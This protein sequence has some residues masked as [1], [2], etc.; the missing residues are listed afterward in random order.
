M[1]FRF[2]NSINHLSTA[3][4]P[5][6]ITPRLV[7][8]A[9]ALWCVLAASAAPASGRP[10]IVTAPDGQEVEVTPV[11]DEHSR[12]FI[13]TQSGLPEDWLPA[14]SQSIGVRPLSKN[15]LGRLSN[16]TIEFNRNLSG[17]SVD[18]TAVNHAASIDYTANASQE[19]T[20]KFLVILVDF[21][22]RPFVT[23]DAHTAFEDIMNS[24]QMPVRGSY[25]SARKY[26][27]EQ[28][29]GQFSPDFDVVGPVT[30][31]RN[32]SY[33]A[34]V[35]VDDSPTGKVVKEACE[36]L[37]DQL[38]FSDYDL[39]G[40]GIC[41][42]IYLFY[43]GKGQADGGGSNTIWPHS[44][45]LDIDWGIFVD[46][47]GVRISNY[48]CSAELNGSGRFSGIGTFCHEF[49][50]V[51]GLPDLYYSGVAHPQYFSLMAS[52]NY[53]GGGYY[54]P[55]LSAYERY[56]LG[57][58]TPEDLLN[59]E[60]ITMEPMPENADVK[61]VRTGAENEYFLLENRQ[62]QGWD[63]YLPGHGLLIWH[64]DY[65]P[66]AW[67]DNIPNAD[68]NHQRVFLVRA[69]NNLNAYPGAA[70]PFPGTSGVDTFDAT[71]SPAFTDWAGNPVD[72]ALSTISETPSGNITFQATT[73]GA[74]IFSPSSDLDASPATALPDGIY[75]LQ[76][77]LLSTST[78]HPGLTPGIY[79]RVTNGSPSKFAVS[80]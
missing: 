64:I 47:D 73:S 41:D 12:R 63:S 46:V 11:G 66:Q 80:R 18:A 77:H 48:A 22:D 25:A 34:S 19:S 20:G 50:H 2:P 51:L 16:P 38:D 5:E 44:A 36:Q 23:A 45:R 39:D 15:L 58:L 14:G 70:A 55:N 78:D 74:G 24:D 10:I 60:W 6:A 67:A 71:T 3:F 79:I 69:N 42:N 68:R 17:G 53:N 1:Q 59:S 27:E 7:A 76:G 57:W 54:P 29:M 52:G 13:Y 26:F 31:S 8:I 30:M 49:C 61:I 40:D 9:V 32:A 72:C 35:G 56:A 4:R 75:T 28:S 21:P 62:Q 33:Y 37:E 65:D 43:A